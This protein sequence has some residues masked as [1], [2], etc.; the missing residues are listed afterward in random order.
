M[1]ILRNGAPEHLKFR[2]RIHQRKD[3]QPCRKDILRPM[4]V[5]EGMHR[6]VTG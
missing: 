6:T 1:K 4:T 3:E 2:F 5:K